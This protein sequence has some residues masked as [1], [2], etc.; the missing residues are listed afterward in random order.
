MREASRHHANISVQCGPRCTPLLY[1][2]IGVYRGIHYFLSFALKHKLWVLVLTYT[3][4]LCFEKN[5]KNI[6]IYHFYSRENYS[7]LHRQVYVMEEPGEQGHMTLWAIYAQF[8]KD[9][10]SAL[11]LLLLF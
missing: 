4:D 1:N 9:Q 10:N 6:T 2:T 8:S 3:N 5:K 7:I 11:K